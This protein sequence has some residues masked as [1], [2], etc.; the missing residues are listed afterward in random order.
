M[1]MSAVFQ[2]AHS[3]KSREEKKKKKILKLYFYID[4][5]KTLILFTLI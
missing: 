4:F 5:F 3:T 1:A 2:A